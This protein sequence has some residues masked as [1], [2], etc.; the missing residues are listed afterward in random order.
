MRFANN[1]DELKWNREFEMK[2]G[3][4]ICAGSLLTLAIF[5]DMVSAPEYTAILIGAGLGATGAMA[6]FA[7]A[8]PKCNA[9]G[10]LSCSVGVVLSLFVILDVLR[11]ALW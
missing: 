4:L 7:L 11:R 6:L 3:M 1:D 9:F 5:W 8:F 2:T 10:R